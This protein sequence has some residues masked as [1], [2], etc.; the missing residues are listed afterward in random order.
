MIFDT[1]AHLNDEKFDD[2]RNEVIQKIKDSKTSLVL[3]CGCDEKTSYECVALAKENEFMYAAVGVHP[4]DADTY[5][6]ELELK[7]IEMTK[8]EKVVAIGEIGLDYYYDFSDRKTQME[9]FIRQIELA[10]RLN[11][12]FIIHSRDASQ[13][14]LD[15]L[16]AHL[17]G[18][19]CVLHSYSQSLEMMK[20]YLKLDTYFSFSG[21]VTF[22]NAHSIKEVA[23]I[24]PMDRFFVE[25]DSPYLTPVPFRGKRNDSSYVEHT[26]RTIAEL[27]GISFEEVCKASME[28][29]KRFFGIS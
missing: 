26:A 29:G 1:H 28:N 24:V 5:T 17:G 3:N 15:T 13:D 21:T 22:K 10:S 25:T 2:D 19:R 11:L 14:T 9:V 12:P 7:L 23:K 27:K 16:K 20:E 4:H 18:N 6:D 8:E